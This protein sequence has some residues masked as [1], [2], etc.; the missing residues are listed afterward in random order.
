[1][2]DKFYIPPHTAEPYA[3]IVPTPDQFFRV[4]VKD[5]RAGDLLQLKRGLFQVVEIKL[6]QYG[7]ERD[8]NLAPL[9]GGRYEW[10]RGIWHLDWM[11][12]WRAE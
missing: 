12:V 5:I 7:R 9:C 11:R 8:L 1:M 2:T 4:Q 6:W 10:E 3:G